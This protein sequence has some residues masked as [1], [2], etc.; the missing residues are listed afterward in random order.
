MATFELRSI[1][2]VESDLDDIDSAPRQADEGAPP[3]WL[4]FDQ[5]VIAGLGTLR[6]GDEIIV[7]TWLQRAR[8]D[9]LRVHPRGEIARPAE[10]VFNTRSPHRP[11]PI[12]LHRA[13]ITQIESTRIAVSALEAINGT[14]IIDIKPVLAGEIELR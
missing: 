2:R 7:L 9:V 3:A 10:G 14:P 11:N 1:G 8:R 13:R 5:E 4:V 6:V 12:G